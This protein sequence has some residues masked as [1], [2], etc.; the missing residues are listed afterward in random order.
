MIARHYTPGPPLGAFVNCFWHFSGYVASHSRERALPNGTTEL[1]VNLHEDRF[2]VYR[3]DTDVHGELFHETVICGPQSRYFVLAPSQQESVIGINF[4]PGGAAPFLG[5]PAGEVTDRHVALED[6]WGPAAAREL[7]ARLLEAGS[8]AAMFA[9]L[10]R[11]LLGR[12]RRPLL[13]HPAVAYALRQLN[14]MP[15]LARIGPVQDQTG[16]GPK[17]FIELFRNSV[18]LTP[19]LYCRIQRFQA[20][21]GMLAGGRRV[22]WATVALESGYFDQSHLNREFRAFSGVTPAGYRP[23]SE[24]RPN[25]V[26]IDE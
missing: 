20:V 19:K 8:S 24:D 7:R 16:Y 26:A 13:P 25:H 22:E 10:E 15:A 12:L 18:G 14:A 9:V 17:R 6:V 5:V 1:V 3:D 21:I 2:R 23:L 11:A 4:R